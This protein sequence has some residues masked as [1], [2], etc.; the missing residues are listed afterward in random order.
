MF[1]SV[2]TRFSLQFPT[3]PHTCI[4]SKQEKKR[5]TRDR[6]FSLSV[7][8]REYIKAQS[9]L[10]SMSYVAVVRLLFGF[11]MI[12]IYLSLWICICRSLIC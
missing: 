5:N 4:T 1:I 11:K 12:I 9:E 8:M 7:M 3:Q 10:L 2:K 6:L